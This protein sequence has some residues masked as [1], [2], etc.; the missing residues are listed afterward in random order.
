MRRGASGFSR[1][2]QF[3]GAQGLG[4]SRGPPLEA[5]GPWWAR[6]LS[7]KAIG[8][9][10]GMARRRGQRL[11]PR[12]AS[13]GAQMTNFGRFRSSP[14]PTPWRPKILTGVCEKK[15]PWRIWVQDCV[16][17]SAHPMMQSCVRLADA[18]CEMGLLFRRPLHWRGHQAS[19]LTLGVPGVVPALGPSSRDFYFADTGIGISFLRER[20]EADVMLCR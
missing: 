13:R 15:V 10:Q 12:T 17:P 18:S 2:H 1:V 11:T 16:A 20:G 9:P 8:P 4:P 5:S 7:Q 3:R 6:G 19:T 14:L